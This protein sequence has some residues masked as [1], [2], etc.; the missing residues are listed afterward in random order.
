MKDK[1]QNTAKDMAITF[2]FV[3]LMFTAT[4]TLGLAAERI[5]RWASP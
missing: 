4:V 5:A 2:L 3:A 1:D